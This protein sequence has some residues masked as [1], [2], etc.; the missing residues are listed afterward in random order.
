[1][2]K[3][4]IA[5][6]SIQIN[7]TPEKIWD[8]MTNPEKIKAYLFGTNVKTDWKV[9]SPIVF[10]GEYQGQQYTDKGNVIESNPNKLLK[11]N[12][13]S[14][15][16][17]LEDQPENYSVVTYK[18]EPTGNESFELTWNQ[19]GFSSEEGKCH[20]EEG[21]KTMLEQIKKLAEE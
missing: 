11:Y 2:D 15:F 14:G 8:V 20:T 9:E 19:Q 18:I 10:Q 21:L 16:S 5:Q 7:T 12:Y 4:L 17:G 3:S 6:S 1:M 13:W